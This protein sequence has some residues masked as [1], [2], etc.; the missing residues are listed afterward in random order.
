[1]NM[2]AFKLSLPAGLEGFTVIAAWGFM[3]VTL[4]VHVCFATGVAIAIRQMKESGRK[5]WFVS[6]E[7]WVLASLIGGVLIAAL[8]WLMHYSALA[9][10]PGQP[11]GP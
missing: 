8:F 4:I 3:V 10:R 5:P 7:V 1:M 9:A 11:P 6:I 2:D